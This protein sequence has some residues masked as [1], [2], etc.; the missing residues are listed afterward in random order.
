VYITTD[1]SQQSLSVEAATTTMRAWD[2]SEQ[3]FK[4]IRHSADS[5]I[6]P[7]LPTFPAEVQS[8][9][10]LEKKTVIN[11]S[12]RLDLARHDDEDHFCPRSHTPDR[13]AAHRRLLYTNNARLAM[14]RKL[15]QVYNP[16]TNTWSNALSRTAAI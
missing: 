6:S 1:S 4:L 5:G 16:A 14:E 12:S 7:T 8:P 9:T 10:S 3:R 11:I 15:V 13:L 2:P